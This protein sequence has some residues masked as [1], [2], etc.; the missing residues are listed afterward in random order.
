[1]CVDCGV[2]VYIVPGFVFAYVYDSADSF[3]DCC[4]SA[5]GELCDVF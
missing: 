4:V 5:V 3:C 2:W 1:M